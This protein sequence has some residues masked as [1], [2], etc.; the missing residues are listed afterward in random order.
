MDRIDQEKKNG[1][2]NMI[3]LRAH[4]S[5]EGN[6]SRRIGEAERLRD[7]IHYKNEQSMSFSSYLGKVQ[8][9]FNIFADQKEPYTEDMKLRFLFRTVQ[10][11]VLSAAIEAIKVRES[12]GQEG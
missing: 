12:I 9:M 11:P 7:S 6:S 10:H 2:A 4:Y 1:R 8:E 3:V 5:G